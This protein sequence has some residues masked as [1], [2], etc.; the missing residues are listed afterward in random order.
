MSQ[1]TRL[2]QAIKIFR[3]AGGILRMSEAL[4]LGIYRRELYHLRNSGQLEVLSRGLYRL[5]DKKLPQFPDFIPAAKRVPRGV[6]C[7]ISAL[8]FHRITTQIPHFVY[9]AI[10]RNAYK[11]TISHPPMRYFWYSEKMLKT[12]ILRYTVDSCSFKIFDIEK[13]L[14]D[15]VKY[16]NKIGM[17]VVL[18]ALKMYW[19][20]GRP[21]MNKLV[22][23]A[24]L[25]RVERILRPIME[26]IISE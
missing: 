20:R 6:I 1:N 21:N 12:G 10:P 19:K 16:R 7:L 22:N 18:E 23:Y 4:R 8:A 14:V 24:R 25:F 5:K 13:T 26:T 3:K 2:K 11:P 9:L 17:D 15:C